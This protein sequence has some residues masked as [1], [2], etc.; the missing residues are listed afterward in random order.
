MELSWISYRTPHQIAF[1][2]MKIVKAFTVKLQVFK[3]RLEPI[4]ICISSP[5]LYNG[6][7]MLYQSM[8]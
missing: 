2:S 5:M 3:V 7:S 8:L 6:V 4:K 1:L